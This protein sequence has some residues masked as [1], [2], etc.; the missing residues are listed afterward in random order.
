MSYRQ[1]FYQIVFGT[2]HRQKVIPETHCRELYQY[3]SGII[4]NKN[5][6]LYRINGTEDHIHIFSDLHPGVSLSDY[7]KD[8][9]VAS[10][11]WMKAN[12]NFPKFG[13]WQEGYGAFTYSSREKDMIINYVKNQKEH[14]K[15]ETFHDEFKRL[16]IETGIEFNE[17]YLL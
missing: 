4:K 3:I 11:V 14:H 1:I 17:K 8:I 7:V 12:G 13:A 6:K 10:S 5:C 9:K 2:K 15:T 16:L